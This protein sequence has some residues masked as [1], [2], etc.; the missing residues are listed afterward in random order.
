[1]NISDDGKRIVIEIVQEKEPFVN[2]DGFLVFTGKLIY[3]K[4]EL[5]LTDGTK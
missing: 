2:K 4:N 5:I 3:N 1:L